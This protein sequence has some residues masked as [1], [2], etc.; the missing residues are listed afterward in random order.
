MALPDWTTFVWPVMTRGLWAAAV[1]AVLGATLMTYFLNFWALAHAK[2]SQVA[3]YIY[4]QPVVAAVIAWLWQGEIPTPR[5]LAASVLI[6]LGMLLA[7]GQI[8]KLL[9]SRSASR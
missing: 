6:F 7:T 9:L 2:S 5:T 8:S 3:L 1:F 4:I